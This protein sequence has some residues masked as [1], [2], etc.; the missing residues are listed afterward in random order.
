MNLLTCERRTA[1]I[2]FHANHFAANHFAANPT[3]G[4]AVQYRLLRATLTIAL[5][6]SPAAVWAQPG[7]DK[8]PLSWDRNVGALFARNCYNCHDGNDPSGDVDLKSDNDVGKIVSNRDKW[9]R[10]LTMLQSHQMPPEDERQPKPEDLALMIEF[11]DQTLNHIDCASASDPGKSVLRRLNR[12]EYNNCVLDLTGLDLRLADEFPPDATGYGFDNIGDALSLT[13][14]QIEMY[15]SAAKKIVDAVVGAEGQSGGSELTGKIRALKTRE[16]AGALLHRFAS[17]AFRRPADPYY[18]NRLL[19]IYDRAI[20][21]DQLPIA[22]MGHALTAV[23]I[24]P[25]F[26]M[27]VE[28]D[29]PAAD[30]DFAPVSD[31]ELAS[32]LSFFLW[33]RGPDDEL[34]QLA[35]QGRLSNVDILRQQVKRMLTDQRSQA[36]VDNF[37]A[38]WLGLRELD[39]HAVD[40][41]KFP[42]FDEELRAAMSQE[43]RLLLRELIRD[44]RSLTTLLD[45]NFTYLNSRLAKHYDIQLPPST[46]DEPP[47]TPSTSSDFIRVPL[48]DRRRG[49]L[50]TSAAFLT[51]QS[52]PG[53]TNIPRRGNFVAGQLLGDPPPPPPPGVPP[54]EAADDGQTRTLRETF[55]LHRASAECKSCH[56]KID[57]IGFSLENYD[58][59][60]RYRTHDHGLPIDVRASLSSPSDE[61]Q[62]ADTAANNIEFSGAEGLKDYMLGQQDA[63][64]RVAATKLM[65]YALGRG[66]QASDECVLQAMQAEAQKTDLRFSSLVIELVTSLPFTHRRPSP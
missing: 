20:A 29:R 50:L 14:A 58:A 10:V 26:L 55:E 65:I 49:G 61:S 4:A 12:T 25:H 8:D 24:S 51:T 11:V 64:L 46:G 2:R 48:S 1:I 39:Q 37:F 9:L 6:L 47:K 57:P 42:E 34:L 17:A 41:S 63:F 62:P 23:L 54:L 30:G 32:R 43:V 52:D 56:A 15:H 38:Q 27:R 16:D 60:G 35:E 40:E 33:S 13:P 28:H 59:T 36:L 53:R 22:A 45:A 31:Y 66:L 18:V 5:L 21:E 19:R 44:D 3:Q 7:K